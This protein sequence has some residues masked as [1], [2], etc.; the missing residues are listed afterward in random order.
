MIGTMRAYWRR[1][2]FPGVRRNLYRE[3]VRLGRQV[4]GKDRRK[5]RSYLAGTGEKKLVLGCGSSILQGWLN[6]D[7]EPVSDEVV[8]L[9]VTV[10]F[11]FPDGV[12][13]C[14]FSEHMIEH[15]SY[16][17]AQ[18][19][20]RECLRVMKPGGRIRISTPNLQF[21]F[22]LY[23]SDKSPL[24]QEYIQWSANRWGAKEQDTHIIN[25]YVREWGHCFIY[26]EKALREAL[27]EA[28]FTDLERCELNGS[29]WPALKNLENESRMQPGFL[30]LETLTME[31]TKRG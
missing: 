26:D 16:A 14:V 28:G 23:R 1:M 27:E 24:Q 31:G 4:A 12:F 25:F 13:E 20:L 22:D 15:I 30:K 10:P 6:A 8:Y 18:F 9:N 7:F 29:R 21:L 11:P 3:F 5:I 19:M 17:D 2:G